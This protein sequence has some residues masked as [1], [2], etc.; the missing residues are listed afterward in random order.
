MTTPNHTAATLAPA[1]PAAMLEAATKAYLEGLLPAQFQPSDG[2]DFTHRQMLYV[3]ETIARCL[4]AADV[5]KLLARI[6]E[7]EKETSQ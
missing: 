6:A 4:N 5:P 2:E 1:I 3:R 7:L